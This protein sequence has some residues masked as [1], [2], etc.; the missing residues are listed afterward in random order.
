MSILGNS[1][2]DLAAITVTVLLA[3]DLGRRHPAIDDELALARPPAD[4]HDRLNGRQ[5]P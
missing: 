3:S 5:P 1:H 2:A 4:H